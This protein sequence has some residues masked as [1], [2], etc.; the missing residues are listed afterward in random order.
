MKIDT[1]KRWWENFEFGLYLKTRLPFH[2]K[3]ILN[4]ITKSMT[5]WVL[6]I[7]FQRNENFI[8]LDETRQSFTDVEWR[9]MDGKNE[10][11]QARQ[12]KKKRN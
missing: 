6:A 9:T 10:K 7:K 5:T 3:H 1:L 8:F 2:Q 12:K 4:T 11:S